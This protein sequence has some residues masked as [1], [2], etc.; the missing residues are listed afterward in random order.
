[1]TNHDVGTMGRTVRPTG[2]TQL[3]QV[4]GDCS[5]L[6]TARGEFDFQLHSSCSPW[7]VQ[8]CS[9]CFARACPFQPMISSFLPHSP[10]STPQLGFTSHAVTPR[11][12]LLVYRPPP[13]AVSLPDTISRAQPSHQQL[14]NPPI[15]HHFPTLYPVTH[16]H[17]T[18][19]NSTHHRKKHQHNHKP[20]TIKLPTSNENV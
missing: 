1:M 4:V 19:H 12:S 6:L 8:F 18:R 2:S 9:V 5:E 20:N 13:I 3:P 14:Y 10:V 11:L 17:Q 15:S 16:H 7:P